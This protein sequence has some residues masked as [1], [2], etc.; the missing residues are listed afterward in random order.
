MGEKL[1]GRDWRRSLVLVGMKQLCLFARVQCQCSRIVKMQVGLVPLRLPSLW[2][3]SCR[4]AH[5][6]R[7][8]A[9][10][11]EQQSTAGQCLRVRMQGRLREDI[12]CRQFVRKKTTP[13]GRATAEAAPHLHKAVV[14]GAVHALQGHNLAQRLVPDAGPLQ[15]STAGMRA[16][17]WPTACRNT[18]RTCRLDCPADIELACACYARWKGRLLRARAPPLF[19]S[20]VLPTL[21]TTIQGSHTPTQMECR[22]ESMVGAV[23][24]ASSTLLRCPVPCRAAGRQPNS[25]LRCAATLRAGSIAP[26]GLNQR[27]RS[28]GSD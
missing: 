19:P 10:F 27:H 28:E 11:T 12:Q 3:S 14:K 23:Q 24:S 21:K 25:R 8:S 2:P 13:R 17:R 7:A 4:T 16:C 15:T 9:A 26:H 20:G 1:E 18:R 22:H 5:S 6:M